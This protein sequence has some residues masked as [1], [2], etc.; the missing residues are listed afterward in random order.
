M[1][2][3]ITLRLLRQ[4]GTAVGRGLLRPEGCG[5]LLGWLRHP[6]L[7]GRCR[8]R[9]RV[10]R[11]TAP[12]AGPRE[13]L[14]EQPHDGRGRRGDPLARAGTA[15]TV[16]TPSTPAP[17]RRRPCST[18]TSR[19]PRACSPGCSGTCSLSKQKKPTFLGAINGMIC[20]LV[21]ITPSAGWVN[22]IGAICR[23]RR[24][25]RSIV[26]IAWNYVSK[27]PAVLEGRR[28]PGSGLHPRLR[29]PDGRALGRHPGRPAHD[30]VRHQGQ[31]LQGTGQLLTWPAGSTATRS[32][33]CGNSSSRPLWIIGWTA[34][35]HVRS[36]STVVKFVLGG[37]REP[38]EDAARR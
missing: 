29:R 22:G 8:L 26:W 16:A 15:S 17:T 23:G 19:P 35:R 31:E 11:R 1:P 7:G 12:L 24:S 20:G 28:R 18:P 38:D 27:R 37:L 5:R 6:P 2:L 32:I 21:A 10:D 36:S 25:R 30:R 3:W 34:H 4:R 33:N 14:P 13:R 9:R